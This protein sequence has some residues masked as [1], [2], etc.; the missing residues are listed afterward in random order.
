MKYLFFI[1][2]LLLISCNT[3]KKTSIK[4]NPPAKGFDL[5]NSDTKAIAIADEVMTAQ[6]G[7]QNWENTRYLKWNFFGNR[8]HVWDKWT[9]DIR[10][11][12]LKEDL[13]IL[14]N[15]HRMEGKA[16]KND[17][18]IVQG[19]DRYPALMQKG[20][21]V[22][23]NDAYWLIMP[24]KLKDSGVTLKYIGEDQTQEGAQA[25]VLALTFK[26]VGNTPNN[27]YLVYVDRS[28]RLVTQWD[29]YTN[30]TDSLPR[31]QTPW[32]VYKSYGNIKLS[33]NRGKFALTNIEVLEVLP[34][35]MLTQF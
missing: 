20:K 30:A 29:F 3:N 17:T 27:K 26:E 13:K 34:K 12:F 6:G 28:S 35:G 8:N 1:V 32:A 18:L 19:D 16:M 11:D 5:T 25:D 24:F 21:S 15:I 9:G 22:W 2:L 4:G 7:R 14:M 23:I 10:V 31:F 33:G